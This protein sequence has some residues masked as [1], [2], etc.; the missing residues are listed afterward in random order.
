MNPERLAPPSAGVSQAVFITATFIQDERSMPLLS[1][2]RLGRE[3]I[4]T[5]EPVDWP[6]LT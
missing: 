6:E 2:A 4:L 1:V 3:A 5:G